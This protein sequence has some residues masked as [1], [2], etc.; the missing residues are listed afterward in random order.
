MWTVDVVDAV[1]V[2]VVMVTDE[3]LRHAMSSDL[4]SSSEP[5]NMSLLVIYLWLAL[6]AVMILITVVIFKYKQTVRY[7][8]HVTH[9]HGALVVHVYL[10]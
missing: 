2:E 3:R 4:G 10:S 9:L 8:H 5:I 1:D 7:T 6:V